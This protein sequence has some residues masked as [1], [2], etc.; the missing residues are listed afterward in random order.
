MKIIKKHIPSALIAPLAAAALFSGAAR[1]C[2]QEI[3][4]PPKP[5]NEEYA[6]TTNETIY[7]SWWW[8]LEI[9]SAGVWNIVGDMAQVNWGYESTANNILTGTGTINLG[10]DTLGGSMYIMGSNPPAPDSNWN[11]I[12]D[13]K[14]TI[15]VNKMGSLS[16]GGSY[17]SRWGRLEFIDT[18]NVNGGIVS[19]MSET[20]NYSYF[21]VKN[22]S[23]RDGGLFESVLDLQTSG[24]GVW[25]LYSQGVSSSKLRVAGGAFT[26][27][28]RAE[29]ALGNL[30]NI[31]VDENTGTNMKL[32]ASADNTLKILELNDKAIIGIEVADGAV[33]KIEKLSSKNGGHGKTDVEFMF[34]DYRADAVLFG[35]SDLSVEGDRLY[36]PSIDTYVLLT[37][38]DSDGYLIEG[39]WF[40]DWN[41][42]SGRLV[43]N[44]V[45][46]PAAVAA[47]LGASAL[48][49]AAR[50]RRD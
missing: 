30:P 3:Q 43:L 29:N 8:T 50:R 27:N 25:D 24:G 41:G 19:I 38:Y 18:L 32:N 9:G 44:A 6:T 5:L 40:Y 45:P 28:L 21:C 17:I 11:L 35:D 14:G 20:E 10:S 15:N 49:F 1:I 36:I 22:L 31:S 16:F 33:F 2:A 12:M 37:A 47:I 7:P 34:Y 4:L 13:F 26:L 46:E 42:E 48:A 23:I 39:E